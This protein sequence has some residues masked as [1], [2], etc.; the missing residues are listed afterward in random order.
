ML[1]GRGRRLIAAALGVV[2]A[3][4]FASPVGAQLETLRETV[5]VRVVNVDVVATDEAGKLLSGLEREDFR[6]LVDGKEVPIEYF[7]AFQGT[8]AGEAA[9]A[10]GA[11]ASETGSLPLLIVNYDARFSRPGTARQ[12]LETLREQLGELLESTICRISG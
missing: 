1:E 12:A 7:S 4:W 10:P 9:G 11:R 8:G 5:E 3:L 6:L 2:L